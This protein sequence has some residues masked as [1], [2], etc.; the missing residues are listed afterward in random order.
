MKNLNPVPGTRHEGPP[1]PF[2]LTGMDHAALAVADVDRAVRFYEEALGGRA[3]YATGFGDPPHDVGAPGYPRRS[4]EGGAPRFRGDPAEAGRTPHVF[5]HVGTVLLQVGYPNDGRTFADRHSQS[6]WPHVAFGASAAVLDRMC[7]HLRAMGVPF[8]G[9]RSHPPVD[10]VSIYFKDPD[11][12]KLEV[13]TWDPYPVE[14]T[15]PLGPGHGL[16]WE[17][18]NH[19]W[20]PAPAAAG[21]E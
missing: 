7:G 9:P 14:R 16:D 15:E 17:A 10:A 20:R 21:A 13:C 18:L 19:D 12:N 6:H 3:Y 8:S 4:E 11:G 2:G 1:N 5:M